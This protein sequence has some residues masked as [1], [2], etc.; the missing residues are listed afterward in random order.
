MI[1]IG[2]CAF[3][4]IG[5]PGARQ[6]LVA[7]VPCPPAAWSTRLALKIASYSGVSG[8]SCVVPQH[9]TGSN[10]GC[11]PL[12]DGIRFPIHW[13]LRS[14]YIAS[15]KAHAPHGSAL[16]IA[17][18]ASVPIAPRISITIL[19]GSLL[20]MRRGLL[21]EIFEIGRRLV[22]PRRHQKSIGAEE[23][24]LPCDLDMG[25]AFRADAFFPVRSRVLHVTIL[26][27][28]RPRTCE[29]VVDRRDLIVEESRIGL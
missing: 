27:E 21:A 10:E 2:E 17:A 7:L 14:G 13:P 29:R 18:S 9:L 12:H 24:T 1:S 4:T 25:V 11:P 3:I 20:A 26:L 5:I 15:S 16:S 22:L 19:L 6:V 28:R 8:A 23:I